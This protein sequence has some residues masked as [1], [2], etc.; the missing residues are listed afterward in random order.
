[1]TKRRVVHAKAQRREGS[2]ARTS[3]LLVIPAK[4]GIQIW[5]PAFAGMTKMGGRCTTPRPA[6]RHDAPATKNFAPSRLCVNKSAAPEPATRQE[7][8]AQAQGR[9]EAA[10]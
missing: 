5:I 1:M 7:V 4:A 9:G 6:E 3:V 2:L 8:R 10:V